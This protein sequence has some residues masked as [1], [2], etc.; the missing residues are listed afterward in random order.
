MTGKQ[1]EKLSYGR[2][3]DVGIIPHLI[4]VQ[5]N[6]YEWFLKEGLKEAFES[7]FPIKDFTGGLQLEFVDYEIKDSRHT[8]D[9]CK[10]K[11][12]TYSVQV[13][14]KLRLINRETGEIKEDN[15][16]LCDLPAMTSTGTFVINGAERV[17][18][19]QL[20]RSPGVY[21]KKEIIKGEG[22]IYH[23][24]VIPNRGTWL[25][26]EIDT[27]GVIRCKIEKSRKFLVSVLLKMLGYV[28]NQ[29]VCQIM[30]G[31]KIKIAS[32]KYEEV[33]Y[34]V[35]AGSVIDEGSQEVLIPAGSI[36]NE[37]RA[38]T[39]GGLKLD[40]LE[41]WDIP[42]PIAKTMIE[43]DISTESDAFR[44]FYR[45][46]RPGEPSTPEI[47]KSWFE[48]AFSDPRRYDLGK[49]GRYRI[50]K[51]LGLGE[52]RKSALLK[53]ED[54]V[55]IIKYLIA[56]SE[57]KVEEDDIDHLGNRRIRAVGEQIQNQFRIG[58]LRLEKL[59]K[60]KMMTQEK[61]SITPSS[62][63]NIR[64]VIAILNEFFGTAQLSQFMDQ[65]NPIA[66]LTHKRRVSAL[67]P[68][69]LMRERAGPGVR[70]VH[71][72]HYGRIC[73]VETPEGP[74]IGLINSLSIFAK[75][76]EY[77]FIETP[78]RKVSRGKVGEEIVYLSADEEDKYIVAQANTPVNESGKIIA[79]RVACRFKDT[80][81]LTEP[82]RVEF[83]DVSAKQIVSITAALIPF[84]EHDDANRA[85]MGSNM[86]RQAVPLI[87]CESPVVQ[88]GI[89]ERVARDS[90]V[91]VISERSGTV[92]EVGIK[93]GTQHFASLREREPYRIV[94]KDN[95]GERHT[96]NLRKFGRSNQGTCIN[97]IP[98][99]SVGD[100][101]KKGQVIADGMSTEQ[102]DLAI[103]RN[104]L[105]A[106]MPWDGYNFEDAILISERLVKDD[107]Y[108][109]I[110]IEEYE[111]EAR[112]TKLGPEEI[113]RELP[114]IQEEIVKDLDE[115]GIIR[116]GADVKSEDILVG[117]ITP[118]GETELTPEEKL[119]RAIFGDK[120]KESRDTSLRVPHG[121]KGKVVDVK[122]FS[123]D[124][125]VCKKCGNVAE[126]AGKCL[127]CK[128]KL[129][130]FGDE[131]P[132][133]VNHIVRVYVAQ[134][135]KIQEG[136]KMAGR[137]GNKGVISLVFPQEDMPYLP[138]GTRVD[139][140]LNP[141]GVP[142][143]M[144]IGQILEAHISFAAY[145][146]GI[147]V[148]SPIFDGAREE[149][150][151]FLLAIANLVRC[152]E[153]LLYYPNEHTPCFLVRW[154]ESAEKERKEAIY[155]V[156]KIVSVI[157][158]WGLELYN[159]KDKQKVGTQS[160]A[161][162]RFNNVSA[163][164]IITSWR[165]CNFFSLAEIE[166]EKDSTCNVK[167][168]R[169]ILG[170]VRV[171]ESGKTILY[172]GRTGEAFETPVTVGYSYICK[173]SHLVD[174]KMHARSIGPYALVTQQ[175][176]GGKAQFGGQRFGEME[177]WALEAYGAA[178]TLQELLTVKSDDV[179]G[180][181]KTYEAIIKGESILECGV[182]ES[183]KVLIKELQA[184]GLNVN[185]LSSN[186]T[187]VPVPEMEEVEDEIIRELEKDI[188]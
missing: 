158:K 144:N 106:Y 101:V 11:D 182:P 60:E 86:Q 175:P 55:D 112:D 124:K 97:Q 52:E 6:S 62:L 27:D 7:V 151:M 108:T 163:P 91:L 16:L 120:A 88:T 141:I 181:V 24:R 186:E 3:E 148:V 29:D 64:P 143:R 172:D 70:D 76:N 77:G 103:G 8:I 168:I 1:K 10:D 5:R 178:S 176:L 129:E 74:N 49:V 130:L 71:H 31:K 159:F 152:G 81:I 30:G 161:S 169:E 18:V 128:E 54:V 93:V 109:S 187:V 188:A 69:G 138:D 12:L 95:A 100:K 147:K 19:N 14:V 119:L 132:P 84:L 122:L 179:V 150:I 50:N 59:A 35:L 89:E 73:P 165:H 184:I 160:V 45:K 145:T 15:V 65:T 154:P 113:T 116:I 46:I 72:T 75:V 21:F 2:T 117:K 134:K 107:V 33:L 44:E 114:G 48:N 133:G 173:L 140:I 20:S 28:N 135:R 94:I 26:L 90:G 57:G 104:V 34:K 51:K 185:L 111:I 41:V 167:E 85:L 149:E 162:L 66:E 123:R 61:E 139:I 99:V 47:A 166:R 177:V 68:G 37:Q 63:I 105:V 102:G 78:Y 183:F 156:E 83:M 13:R 125:Y 180:R 131:L 153:V 79:D 157:R 126:K 155:N 87:S 17:V 4:E 43:D 42:L 146:L 39:I 142:S 170:K 9:E 121:G 136:D 110:H 92:V 25:E 23:C 80:N 40:E 58:L 67:G 82:G 115:R 53:K 164:E 96:Y 137:H 36:I 127:K 32:P 38:R 118:K 98:L 174:D 22:K 171:K 56:F